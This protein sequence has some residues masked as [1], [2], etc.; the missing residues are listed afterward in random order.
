MTQ[1]LGAWAPAPS[2]V[3]AA[4]AWAASLPLA[5]RAAFAAAWVCAIAGALEALAAAVQAAGEGACGR[6]LCCCG[7]GARP[8]IRDSAARLAAFAWADV[9]YS[10]VN[11]AT[12]ALFVWHAAAFAAHGGCSWALPAATPAAAA[13]FALGAVVDVA[14]LFVAYDAFYY[15]LHRALHAPALYGAI[16][17]HH[18]RQTSPFRGAADAV[19]VHPVE[20]ALGEYNHLLVAHAAGRA[21]PALG[22]PPLHAAAAAFFVIVGGILAASARRRASSHPHMLR[23]LFAHIPP[24]LLLTM[25]PPPLIPP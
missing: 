18:H 15:W 14:A 8:R 6:G 9:A 4:L 1:L 24:C 22:L 5:G 7:S 16:H 21:L 20:F 19:N 2:V 13:A 11:K 3:T 25:R 12:T 17:K 23:A 10:G